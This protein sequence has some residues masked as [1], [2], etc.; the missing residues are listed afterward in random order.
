MRDY[1]ELYNV[2]DVLLLADVFENFRDV[3]M[4]NYRLDPVG[5]T[6]HPV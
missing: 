5:I 2:S 4:R 1:H 6:L 3:C